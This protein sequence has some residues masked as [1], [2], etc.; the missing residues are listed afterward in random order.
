[1]GLVGEQNVMNH[2]GV[3]INPTAQ[4]QPATRVHIFKM[5]IALDMEEIHF[6]LCVMFA[7][8]S[9]LKQIL[10][11]LIPELILGHKYHTV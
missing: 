11:G 8:L 5:L 7:R 1:V 10:Q 4:F 3:R 2:M 9:Q 6:L